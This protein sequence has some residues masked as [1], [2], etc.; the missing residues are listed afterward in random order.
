MM[1]LPFVS[2]L[3]SVLLCGL[4]IRYAPRDAPDGGRKTQAAPVPTSGGLAIAMAT[5]MALYI[6]PLLPDTGMA[7]GWTRGLTEARLWPYAGLIF[8]C[9]VIGAIDDV[10]PLPARAKLIALLALCVM[11]A[12]FGVRADVISVPGMGIVRLPFSIAVAGTTAFLIVIIN[13][14][15]FMDG[16]DG[17]AAGTLLAPLYVMTGLTAFAGIFNAAALSWSPAILLAGL[18]LAGALAGF[19]FWNVRGRLY[20]GDSG[21]LLLG[22]VLGA[23]SL[24]TV[25]TLGRA[26]TPGEVW[27]PVVL[28]LPFLIDVLMTLIWRAWRGERLFE[29]HREH[30]YQLLR[31]AGWPAWSVA[32]LWWGLS[33]VCAAAVLAP[34]R[35]L[36]ASE[37]A[38]PATASFSMFILLTVAGAALWIWQRRVF[39]RK[40]DRLND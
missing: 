17:L 16:S 18:S 32:V 39:D 26:G 35:F 29:A 8:G 15:N 10:R 21:S 36:R 20:L 27:L 37:D 11:A 14:V 25:D 28:V 4:M 12:S 33:I 31:R 13:A 19:L 6:S 38:G 5:V 2:L 3:L 40:N 24:N 23:Q 9:L 7:A 34:P 1:L 22:A 30:A